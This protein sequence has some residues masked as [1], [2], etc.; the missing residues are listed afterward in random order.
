VCISLAWIVASD[1]VHYNNRFVV[2]E[3]LDGSAEEHFGSGSVVR[4]V[5]ISSDSENTCHDTLYI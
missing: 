3:D 2:L 1:A 5:N 4:K